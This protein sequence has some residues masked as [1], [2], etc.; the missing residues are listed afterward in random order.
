MAV[1]EY[2]VSQQCGLT[3]EVVTSHNRRALAV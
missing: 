2:S 1:A 3:S